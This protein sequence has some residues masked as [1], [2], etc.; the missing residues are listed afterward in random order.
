MNC[1]ICKL[2]E[3]ITKL[4]EELERAWKAYD[5]ANF[6]QLRY[7]DELNNVF[8]ILRKMSAKNKKGKNNGK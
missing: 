5:R 3:K 8:D 1:Q 7:K 6:D 4:E 2:E